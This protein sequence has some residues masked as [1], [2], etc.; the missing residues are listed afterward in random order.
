EKKVMT[1]ENFKNLR[2]EEEITTLDQKRS[3]LFREWINLVKRNER[4]EELNG[5]TNPKMVQKIKDLLDQQRSIKRK[6]FSLL[7][8][9]D[10]LELSF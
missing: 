1:M 5:K 7:L 6:I 3:E 8:S 10:N 9:G 4:E 2:V